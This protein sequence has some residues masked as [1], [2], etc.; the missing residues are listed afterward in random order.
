MST[1]RETSLN[2]HLP[3]HQIHNSDLA[4]EDKY[5]TFYEEVIQATGKLVAQWQCVGFCHG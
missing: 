2:L 1:P 5:L 3:I 4:E